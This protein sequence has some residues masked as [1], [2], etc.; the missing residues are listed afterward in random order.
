M[1]INVHGTWMHKWIHKW[2]N[3]SYS[4]QWFLV[5]PLI[6]SHQLIPVDKLLSL[7]D[8]FYNF[9]CRTF[10][11]TFLFCR[12]VPFQALPIM[13]TWE[14]LRSWEKEVGLVFC[15]P[16]VPLATLFLHQSSSSY[17]Q[18]QRLN[19]V[20]SFLQKS[21]TQHHCSSS[22]I[23]APW[24]GTS[25]S[26]VWFPSSSEIPVSAGQDPLLRAQSFSCAGPFL[27]ALKF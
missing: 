26:K 2:L 14:R 22:E 3:V 21:Q 15:L 5:I 16:P 8:L 7:S 27:Q 19:L 9:G 18:W 1:C 4:G 10:H 24:A 12:L 6:R 11:I 25:P 13:D 20:C 17:I 23:P